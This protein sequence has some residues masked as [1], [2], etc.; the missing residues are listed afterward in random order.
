MMDTSSD[1]TLPMPVTAKLHCSSPEPFTVE[2]SMTKQAE[3]ESRGSRL[4]CMCQ[5]I[6]FSCGAL[7]LALGVFAT[8][9]GAT[10]ILPPVYMV[11][12]HAILRSAHNE[13]SASLASSAQVG[14]VGAAVFAAPLFLV[15]SVISCV[16]G[17]E[18]PKFNI[19]QSV[20]IA[21]AAGI[22]AFSGSV[23]AS[24]LRHYGHATLDVLLAT[25]AGALGGPLVMTGWLLI[26]GWN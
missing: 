16:R 5:K 15:C 24:I 9:V 18:A 11:T 12:G 4:R 8:I 2:D 10:M 1:F 3:A 7:L 14:A 6:L 13:Y 25:R 20:K 19:P 22:G 17:A 26:F 23:G 21:L